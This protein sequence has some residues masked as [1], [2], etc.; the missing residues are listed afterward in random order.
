MA[1][2]RYCAKQVEAPQTQLCPF[3]L[4]L[5]RNVWLSKKNC[6]NWNVITVQ[7]I[8]SWKNL[9][10]VPNT[11]KSSRRIQLENK[12]DSVKKWRIS[13]LLLFRRF[14]KTWKSP[15][16][17]WEKTQAKKHFTKKTLNES[18]VR[19]GV[20]FLFSRS[21]KS[22]QYRNDFKNR[23]KSHISSKNPPGA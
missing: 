7:E 10:S 17:P 14:L 20:S 13:P 15:D 19:T 11:M 18:S 21:W 16:L 9:L 6:K 5:N 8:P 2:K 22:R 23:K 3:V 12:K 1:L 4:V